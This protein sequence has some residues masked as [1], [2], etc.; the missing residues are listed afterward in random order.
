MTLLT[1][2][3]IKPRKSRSNFKTITYT[4]FEFKRLLGGEFYEI[5]PIVC[6]TLPCELR[7]LWLDCRHVAEQQIIQHRGLDSEFQNL[8]IQ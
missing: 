4:S 8:P 6:N 7:S 2:K 3:T 5:E 1:I